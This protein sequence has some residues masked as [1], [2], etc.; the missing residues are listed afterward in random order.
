MRPLFGTLLWHLDS[1][2]TIRTGLG[3]EGGG[4][5]VL[6][7]Q[8]FTDISGKRVASIFKVKEDLLIFRATILEL[9]YCWMCLFNDSA[10]CKYYLFNAERLIKTSRKELFK[11]KNPQ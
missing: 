7:G 11:N 5:A 1:H 2:I 6:P 9:Q 8:K 3:G 10:T 4:D